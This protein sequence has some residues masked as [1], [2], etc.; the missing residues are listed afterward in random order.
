MNNQ[1][2]AI[3]G[4][5]I[6]GLYLGWKLSEKEHKV[7]IFEKEKEVG[8]KACSGLFSGRILDFLPQ[9]RELIENQINYTKIHF[10]KKTVKVGFSKSFFVMNHSR[11]DKLVFNSAK[12]AGVRIILNHNVSFIPKGFDRIIGCDGANSFVRKSLGL[13]N[14]VFRLG[15]LGFVREKSFSDFVETWPCKGGFIWKIPRGKEIEYGII[16]EPKLAKSI[17]T[18]FLRE[19]KIT[20]EGIKSKIVPQGLIIPSH[21]LITLCG[22]AA[23]LTKPW[24]GGGVIWGLTAAEILL[25]TFPNFL[26]YRKT[27]R[28]FFLPKII[29]SK[30]AVKIIYF[31]G[32]K[33]PWL[34]PKNTKIESDFLL[35]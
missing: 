8:N 25:K 10:P 28:R 35:K 13:P 11:L 1:K 32:F 4:A 31:L 12:K 7:T 3:I 24:S 29:R 22:D 16:S 23:G 18:D 2:V 26:S 5:G 34:L 9:S 14:P 33:I 15:I 17:F 30:L 27:V 6:S 19:N 20:L 21:S